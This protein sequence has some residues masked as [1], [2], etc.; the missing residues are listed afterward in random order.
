MVDARDVI[1][2]LDTTLTGAGASYVRQLAVIGAASSLTAAAQTRAT[3]DA[4]VATPLSLFVAQSPAWAAPVAPAT[5][6]TNP[7]A[8]TNN[9]AR[10]FV[11]TAAVSTA[12]NAG[13][14]AAYN[15][16][17]ADLVTFTITGDF[18]GVASVGIDLNNNGAI[19]AA[20]GATTTTAE[21]FTINTALTSATLTVDGD[22]LGAAGGTQ[23]AVWFTKITGV[24]LNP[25]VFAIQ[26]TV[27]P[28]VASTRSSQARSIGT[29]APNWFQW[30]QNGTTIIAPYVSFTPGNGV[31]FRFANSSSNPVNVLV[32]VVLDQGTFT[33]NV[34]MFS[35]PPA[36]AAQYTFSDAPSAGTGEQGPIATLLTGTQPVRGKVTFTALTASSN[37]TGI[38]LIYSPVGVVTAINLPQQG[39]NGWEK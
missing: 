22:R 36:G 24:Q 15:L 30:V 35:I 19:T 39:D 14:T 26:A 28:T 16:V 29:S 20:A 11:T 7:D 18:T 33:Q 1:S 17:A 27:N 8:D 10:A 34:N 31:K 23:S 13:N 3:I 9:V 2:A 21:S 25:R 32:N 5:T 12:R 6:P 38:Q 37:V 4:T